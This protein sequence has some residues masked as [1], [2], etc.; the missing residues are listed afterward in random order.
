MPSASGFSAIRLA[1]IQSHSDCKTW[2]HSIES[3]FAIQ[4]H[5]SDYNTLDCYNILPNAPFIGYHLSAIQLLLIV[6]TAVK[7]QDRP[8]GSS[9]DIYTY[10]AR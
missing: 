7:N 8:N 6:R 3:S 1:M 9:L 2:H 4:V 10:T 5:V